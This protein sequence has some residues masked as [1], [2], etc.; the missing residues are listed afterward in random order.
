LATA[1]RRFLALSPVALPG[2]E[3]NGPSNECGQRQALKAKLRRSR[4]GTV[5][6]TVGRKSKRRDT[7]HSCACDGVHTARW[8]SSPGGTFTR[9]KTEGYC[10]VATRG[11]EL[12]EVNNPS[13]TTWHE[14]MTQSEP[15]SAMPTGEPASAERSPDHDP[16]RT[17]SLDLRCGVR[18]SGQRPRTERERERAQMTWPGRQGGWGQ[19]GWKC[20]R[21]KQGDPPGS[22]RSSWPNGPKNCLA[23]VRASIVAKKRGNA[24]GAKGCRKVEAQKP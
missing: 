15:D 19:K 9:L 16:R 24:R 2:A 13:V 7:A 20:G 11:G 10:A 4:C 18:F 12:P 17:D 22:E 21:D 3:E 23:G 8:K 5:D 6:E 1:S 14:T